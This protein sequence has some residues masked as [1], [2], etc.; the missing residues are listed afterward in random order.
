MC[1]EIGF[2][3][4]TEAAKT[5][6]D[7]SLLAQNMKETSIVPR[8][9]KLDLGKR[10]DDQTTLPAGTQITKRPR[11]GFPRVNEQRDSIKFEGLLQRNAEYSGKL[12]RAIKQA[13]SPES[14]GKGSRESITASISPSLF[15]VSLWLTPHLIDA[16]YAG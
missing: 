3:A 10:F 12:A 9:L 4:R 5:L 6:E 2:M 11:E 15:G 1:L 7:W 14:L 13:T 16:E 8:T